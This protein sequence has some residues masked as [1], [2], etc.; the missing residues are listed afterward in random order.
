MIHGASEYP[1]KLRVAEHPVE[2]LPRMVGSDRFEEGS[3]LWACA[4][5]R[6]RGELA[7]QARCSLY[8]SILAF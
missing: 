7:E 1:E 2:V 6:Q 8:S 4:G 3:G 5:S